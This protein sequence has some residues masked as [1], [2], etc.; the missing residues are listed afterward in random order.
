[1][2]QWLVLNGIAL[3]QALILDSGQCCRF[4]G[5]FRGLYGFLVLFCR[6]VVMRRLLWVS[7]R[8]ERVVFLELSRSLL[9]VYACSLI[10]CASILL[11]VLAMIVRA[12]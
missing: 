11:A 7:F 2:N 8:A 9:S 1:M 3:R 10:M 5:P 12:S 6:L 4:A